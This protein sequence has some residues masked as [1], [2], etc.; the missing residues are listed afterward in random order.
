LNLSSNFSSVYEVLFAVLF[1]TNVLFYFRKTLQIQII[2]FI[3]KKIENDIN[4]IEEIEQ[5][6]DI[7]E[8]DDYL[9]ERLELLEYIDKYERIKEKLEKET[10][11]DIKEFLTN[12]QYFI[13]FSA[14]YILG[15]MISTSMISSSVGYGYTSF[16]LIYTIY[17]LTACSLFI[18]NC[19]RKILFFLSIL[20][21]IIPLACYLIS[22]D[23]LTVQETYL[24]N[25]K[26]EIHKFFTMTSIYVLFLSILLAFWKY[27]RFIIKEVEKYKI[28]DNDEKRINELYEVL[29][30][31]KKLQEIKIDLESQFKKNLKGCKSSQSDP[32]ELKNIESQVLDELPNNDN[33]ENNVENTFE[34]EIDLKK[35]PKK[36]SPKKKSSKKKSS[37]KKSSKKK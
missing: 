14:I 19:D 20:I 6:S 3:E 32:L 1:A 37:K 27:F 34:K 18:V 11:K 35:S 31:L 23:F 16:L 12:F 15:I 7:N 33:R 17:L 26:I 36:K 2:N 30:E 24:L 5:F 9:S 10:K 13:S 28:Q 29:N 4:K 22:F 25:K 21:I 8:T